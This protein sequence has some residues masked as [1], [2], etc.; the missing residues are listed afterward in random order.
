MGPRASLDACGK[1][2]PT[3]IRSPDR[4]VRS[5]SLYQLSYPS[6]HV[7]RILPVLLSAH[8]FSV[9]LRTRIIQHYT[10]IKDYTGLY[11]IMPDYTA[12]SR[13]IKIVPD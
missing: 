2:R 5:E 13:I 12:L 6:L 8:F 1:P 4:P 11:S 9:P 3:G 10:G 7:I